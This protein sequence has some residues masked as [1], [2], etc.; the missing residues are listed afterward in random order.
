[1]ANDVDGCIAMMEVLVPGFS[2]G[3]AELET[4]RA[5][6]AWTRGCYLLVRARVEEAAGRFGRHEHI[7]L[8]FAAGA[9]PLFMREIAG[10]HRDL[11]DEQEELYGENIRPK[12]ERCLTVSE[13]DAAEAIAARGAYRETMEALFE[14]FDLLVTPTMGFVAPPADVDEIAVRDSMTRFTFPFNA[15]GWPALALP[16]GPAEDGLPASIQVVGEP[17]ADELVLGVGQALEAA[18]TR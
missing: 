18:L 10:V 17:G 7:E 9:T 16:C 6:V 2:T 13:A 3:E 14:P 1:M 12:I 15:L 8:P 5:G 4:L 11:Y